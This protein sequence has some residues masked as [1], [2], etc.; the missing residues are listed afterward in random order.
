MSIFKI[1]S[2]WGD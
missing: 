2:S 1:F